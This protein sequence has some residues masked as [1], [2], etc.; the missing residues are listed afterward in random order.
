MQ[1]ITYCFNYN[2]IN[3]LENTDSARTGSHVEENNMNF[4][5]VV[6]KTCVWCVAAVMAALTLLAVSWVVILAGN[7]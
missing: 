2:N 7:I 6:G 5:S 4:K 1:D 3:T